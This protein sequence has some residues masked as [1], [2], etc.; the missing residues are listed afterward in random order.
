VFDPRS[1]T[2]SATAATEGTI[3][4][5][6][7]LEAPDEPVAGAAVLSELQGWRTILRRL[8]LL[9]QTPERYGGFG[10][11]NLSTRDGHAPEQFLITASQTSG[12]DH[13]GYDEVVRI[14]NANPLRFWVD[15]Q[16]YQPP[17]SE[18]LTHA[19][20][21]QADARISWIFHGHSPDIWTRARVLGLLATAESVAYGSPEMVEA[22]AT[23][24]SAQPELP[25][26]FVTLGHEDGVFACGGSAQQTGA[27]LVALLAR[28]LT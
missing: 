13:I 8:G 20:I 23:L 15:A 21:Y 2:D 3:R 10:F 17:S 26:T 14:V 11:G 18:S 16:G 22:V 28:A 5:A 27:A 7:S 24:L 12:A 19:M 1:A 9:G 25:L 6:Y 4:F